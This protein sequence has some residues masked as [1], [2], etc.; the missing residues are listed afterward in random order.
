MLSEDAST[1]WPW[2]EEP[3]A[4]FTDDEEPPSNA[5]AGSGATTTTESEPSSEFSSAATE[6]TSPES[7]GP[8]PATEAAPTEGEPGLEPESEPEGA[9][10]SATLWLESSWEGN[11]QVRVEVA[12]TGDEAVSGWEVTVAIDGVDVYHSWGMHRADGDRY[13]NEDWNGA[14]GPGEAAT[15]TFQ[16][17]AEGEPELPDAVP[18]TAFA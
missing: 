16:A 7:G 5:A 12:N 13:R 6:A 9:S 15:G 8:A 10:C 17:A 18:C 2:Q 11:V 4:V 1:A 3:T 14:L